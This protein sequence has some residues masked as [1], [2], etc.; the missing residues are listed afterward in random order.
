MQRQ[1]VSIS[2]TNRSLGLHG[3]LKMLSAASLIAGTAV[4]A[5]M[6]A[7]PFATVNISLST[8]II[9]FVSVWLVLSYTGKL[10]AEVASNFPVG[11][12]LLGMAQKTLGKKWAI[13]ASII[14]ALFH[15]CL[16]ASY[17]TGGSAIIAGKFVSLS[18]TGA[19]LIFTILIAI[20]I[21]YGVN[22]VAKASKIL[23]YGILVTY[24]LLVK[25]LLQLPQIESTNL[26]ETQ[27]LSYTTII[28]I[29]ITSFG[30]H[31]V[32]PSLRAYVGNGWDLKKAVFWGSLIPLIIYLIWVIA[33][34]NVIPIS[35]A[36]ADNQLEGLIEH[37]SSLSLH[38]NKLL[39]IFSICALLSSVLGVALSLFDFCYE[40]VGRKIKTQQKLITLL[41]TFV[42]PVGL[43]LLCPNIF[44][45][46]LS[47]AGM[48]ACFL[49]VMLPAM[50]KL[51]LSKDYITRAKLTAVI[52]I[53]G[54]LLIQQL[55]TYIF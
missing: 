39:E 12:N 37:I 7:L 51:K 5:G 3:K 28:M 2:S 18:M 13:L 55:I 1:S 16:L 17:I 24:A 50:M 35:L 21:L 29:L 31:G 53:A 19:I 34:N 47:F 38:A 41:I 30:F 32:I 14:F 8:T 40:T 45:I 22:I 20:A 11:A 23:T 6:L 43:S 44:I 36:N 46:A 15:Y 27:T 42:P 33:A 9:L 52:T 26:S 10:L 48:F 4:G 54:S 49:L 25:E